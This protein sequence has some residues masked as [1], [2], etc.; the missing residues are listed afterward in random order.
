MK[1]ILWIIL[2]FLSLGSYAQNSFPPSGDAFVS[3]KIISS[4]AGADIGGHLELRNP[5]KTANGVASSWIIFNMAGSYG[6]SLQF[7]AYDNIGCSSGGMCSSRLTLMDNGNLGIGTTTP[8]SK[9]AV[10]G[11]IRAQEVKVENAN[12]PDYVFTKDYRLPTL[13]QTEQHIKEK[14]HLPGIPSAVEVKT[15][16][17]DLGEMNAKLL[18]KIEE[19]TLYI[20][21][22]EKRVKTIEIKN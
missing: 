15:N 18:Q 10:N 4:L 11:N 5:A 13:E 3:G 6:N 14:G 22:L 17:I 21:D 8:S 1:H 16:G 9:L 12:W 2:I 19:L 7:W 20:I